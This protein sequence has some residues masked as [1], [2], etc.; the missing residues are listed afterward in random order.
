MLSL[1]PLDFATYDSSNDCADLFVVEWRNAAVA[2]QGLDHRQHNPGVDEMA[3]KVSGKPGE[4][5]V[6]G[7]LGNRTECKCA[8]LLRRSGGAF[9]APSHSLDQP[10]R[11]IGKRHMI[12]VMVDINRIS[13]ARDVQ[14]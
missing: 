10:S 13:P 5:I 2:V 1:P 11:H 9:A 3:E 14:T 12:G 8:P 6:A 4:R 7:A